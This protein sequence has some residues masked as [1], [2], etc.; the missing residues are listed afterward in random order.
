[1][2]T[3][4]I[5]NE[6]PEQREERLATQRANAVFWENVLRQLPTVPSYPDAKPSQPAM[7]AP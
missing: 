3:N 5:P 2:S 4:R 1:M 7:E 6:T